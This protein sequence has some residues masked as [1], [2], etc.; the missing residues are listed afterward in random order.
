[1][2]LSEQ[3]E[4]KTPWFVYIYQANTG[5]YYVD[6]TNDPK[7]RLEK[8]NS[9][10]GSKFAREQGPFTLVYVSHPLQDKSTAR[11]REIQLKGWSKAKKEKLISGEYK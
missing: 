5:R 4:S 6:I 3:S 9:G 1:M 2:S 11:K 10:I 7:R 8:H